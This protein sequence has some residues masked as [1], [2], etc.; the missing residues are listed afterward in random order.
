M[1]MPLCGP[2]SNQPTNQPT[3]DAAPFSV[4]VIYGDDQ[5]T[6]GDSVVEHIR[7]SSTCQCPAVLIVDSDDKCPQQDCFDALGIA[8]A[9]QQPV[10]PSSIVE[11]VMKVGRNSS[12]QGEHQ[13]ET[14]ILRSIPRQK[15]S[16]NSSLRI[17]LVEDNP[18]NQAVAARM[19]KKQQHSVHVVGN[20]Q[21]ALDALEQKTFDV[22]LMD[23]QMPVLDGMQAIAEIRKREERSAT[24]IPVIAMTANAMSGDRERCLAAGMDEYISKPIDSKRLAD[25]IERMMTPTM[26]IRVDRNG[27]ES[28]RNDSESLKLNA[29]S[30]DKAVALE[31]MDGDASLLMEMAEVF[32]DSS[33][34]QIKSLNSAVAMQQRE[35]VRDVAHSIKGAVRYFGAESAFKIAGTLESISLD[36]DADAIE[37]SCEELLTE[38]QKLREELETTLIT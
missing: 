25:T 29:M 2:S 10:S 24:R 22:V 32:L 3:N 16:H 17:L 12:E 31:N 5:S 13:D 18:V 6:T 11:A 21:L 23:I 14:S 26:P 15:A 36:G 20:G 27:N 30:F 38:I 37:T 9:F 35:L 19:L 7:K 8:A 33:L 4:L 34:L 1:Q 28:P